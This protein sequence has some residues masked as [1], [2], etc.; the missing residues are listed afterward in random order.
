MKINKLIKAFSLL[1][2]VAFA[3]CADFEDTIIDSPQKSAGNQE[4]FPIFKSSF[5]T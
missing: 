5:R 1:L 2:V 3:A 4:C